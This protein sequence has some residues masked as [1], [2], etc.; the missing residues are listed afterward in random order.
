MYR[1]KVKPGSEHLI[2]GGDGVRNLGDGTVESNH[3]LNSPYL[4]M[5]K[6][7]EAQAAQPQIPAATKAPGEVQMTATP[8]APQLPAPAPAAPAQSLPPANQGG[9]S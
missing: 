6:E 5:I 3:E 8:A 7:L 9:T 1:Y 4:E 2:V